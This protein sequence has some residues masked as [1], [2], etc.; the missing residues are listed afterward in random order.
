M[1]KEEKQE[2][3]HRREINMESEGVRQLKLGVTRLTIQERGAR[4]NTEIRQLEMGIQ[5]MTIL[6][7]IPEIATVR[8]AIRGNERQQRR[9][10]FTNERKR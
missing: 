6:V 4:D 3:D 1:R 7:K 5:Q 10:Q 9:V 8:N 2:Q